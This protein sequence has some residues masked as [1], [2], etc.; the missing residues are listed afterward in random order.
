MVQ[1]GSVV[2]YALSLWASVGIA[3]AQTPTSALPLPGPLKPSA[4]TGAVIVRPAAK[5]PAEN[6]ARGESVPMLSL[7]DAVALAIRDNRAIRA[8]Y[9]ARVAQRFNLR[10]AEARFDPILELN[11]SYTMR[12]T[13]QPGATSH[14]ERIASWT[15]TVT[16]LTPTGAQFS[17]D[18]GAAST[19]GGLGPNQN[20]LSYGASVIQPLLQGFGLDVNRAPVIQ[21]RLSEQVAILQLYSTVTSQVTAVIQ[22]YR[23]LVQAREQVNIARE[24]KNSALS[25]LAVNRELIAAGRMAANDVLQTE[26]NVA[27]QEL[28]LVQAENAQEAARYALLELLALNTDSRIDLS[29]QPEVREVPVDMVKSLDLAMRYRPDWRQSLL[30]LEVT[31]LTLLLA[32]DGQRWTL[33]LVAGGGAN[34]TANGLSPTYRELRDTVPGWNVGLVLNIPIGRLSIEQA[35]VA[36][37]TDVAVAE[38]NLEGQRQAIEIEVRNAVRNVEVAWRSLILARRSRELAVQKLAIERDKLA[39]GRSSNFQVVSYEVETVTAKNQELQA[40]I[41]YLNSLTNLDQILGTTLQTWEIDIGEKV[42]G[43]AR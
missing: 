5:P 2:A 7:V 23:N 34:R 8:N 28:S 39:A 32:Q 43:N 33:N 21:A 42:D 24:A 16:M 40:E 15:P 11:A 30:G 36:A 20:G 31:R 41:G 1:W 3:S 27:V 4:A 17:F 35:V 12:R 14:A 18:A 22:A 6:I 37:K 10:V 29:P 13:Q 9:L 19:R 38:V 26:A 25:L